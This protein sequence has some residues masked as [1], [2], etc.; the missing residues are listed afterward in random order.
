MTV[1][2]LGAYVGVVGGIMAFTGALL[3]IGASP[4]LLPA[5][6]VYGAFGIV[7]GIAGG[8]IAYFG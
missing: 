8:A 1:N 4:L 7:L 5:A 6:A 2:Q 3:C